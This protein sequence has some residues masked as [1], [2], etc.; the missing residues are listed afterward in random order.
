[1]LL[2]PHRIHGRNNPCFSLISGFLG[3]PDN[4]ER[5]VSDLHDL[6]MTSIT[7]DTIAFSDYR[8]Q[9]LLVVNLASQ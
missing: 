3:N 6:E 8:D 5:T 4:K 7:G 2:C 9:A 1:M